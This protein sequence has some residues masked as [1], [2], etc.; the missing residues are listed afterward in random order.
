MENT[1]ISLFDTP[2]LQCNNNTMPQIT[3]NTAVV[4]FSLDS[5]LLSSFDEVI[6]DAG[7]TRSATLAEL[8]KRYVWMQRWEKI[9]EYGREKA[10]ELGITSEEDVYRL[11]GDA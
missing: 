11:M 2:V 9:R 8:M 5:Q 3:R 10:K 6:K 7:Q 4:S 1:K